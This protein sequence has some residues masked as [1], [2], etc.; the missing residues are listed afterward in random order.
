MAPRVKRLDV[1]EV[2][3]GPIQTGI[4][5]RPSRR[6][7]AQWPLLYAA[8]LN[9]RLNGGRLPNVVSTSLDDCELNWLTES[10]RAYL[11]TE[12]VL[13]TAAAAGVTV[14]S[15]SGDDGSSGCRNA[16]RRG[17]WVTFP[18]TSPYVTSVGGT[19]LTL[20]R[21]NRIRRQV[22]WN[23]APFGAQVAGGGGRSRLVRRPAYQRGPGVPRGVR[24]AVPDIAFYADAVPGYTF[25][26]AGNAAQGGTPWFATGGT[27]ISAPMLAGAVAL[28]DQRAR[29]GGRARI[30]LLNPSLYALARRAYGARGPV[31]RDVT[32]GTNDLLGI[33][34]CRARR[35][36]DE[37]TGWGSLDLWRFSTRLLRLRPAPIGA[38]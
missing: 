5:N 2:N 22:V 29:Q 24:R 16:G 12:H 31:F 9:P 35:N 13:M 4:E 33:G 6:L 21:A 10:R 19:S 32:R 15:S 34:C 20:N 38:R 27:S 1:Y 36:F 18:S 11:L 14:V 30:G 3:P 17:P 37:A 28:I 25:Y 8:P 7:V 26:W 23:D